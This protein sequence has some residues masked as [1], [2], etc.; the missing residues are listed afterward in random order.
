MII[1]V[2]LASNQSV[3]LVLLTGGGLTSYA[4]YMG[5]S[6]NAI[7]PYGILS[8]KNGATYIAQFFDRNTLINQTSFS[9]PYT[10]SWKM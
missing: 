4:E 3:N 10:P 5:T 7:T 2:S 6:G 1:N 9:I 8:L